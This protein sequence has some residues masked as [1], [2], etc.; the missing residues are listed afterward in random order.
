MTM[1]LMHTPGNTSAFEKFM[2]EC[3]DWETLDRPRTFLFRPEGIY[4]QN[5]YRVVACFSKTLGGYADA[6]LRCGQNGW[7]LFAFNNKVTEERV[8][9]KFSPSGFLILAYEDKVDVMACM[10][11]ILNDKNII[12]S[13]DGPLKPSDYPKKE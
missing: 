13:V 9:D 7:D 1:K 5:G 2:L 8:G 3:V 6:V 4:K 10:Q 12:R 11:A